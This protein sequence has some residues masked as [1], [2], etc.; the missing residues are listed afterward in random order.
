ME[1]H[2]KKIVLGII[3]HVD[4]GKTTL[5][6]AMLYEAGKI[7]KLGR[8]DHQDAYLDTDEQEKKRGITI[9]SKQ[10]E[11][12]YKNMNITLL[13]T[14]GHVDFSAEMER[15]LQVL[16]YAILVINGMDGVQ[17]HTDT[18][19][20]LL[21]RYNIPAFI[22]INKMDMNG[23]DKESIMSDIRKRLDDNC[24]DMSSEDS[25]E[26]IAMCDEHIMETYLETGDIKDSLISS[27]IRTRKLFPCY[28]GSALKLEGVTEL[29]DSMDR[30][31][32]QPDYAEQFGARVFKISRDV[33]GDR[34]TH[35]KLTGGILKCRDIIGEEKVNQ[36]RIYSGARF[37]NVDMVEAGCICAIT[38]LD[39]TFAGQGLG[40]EKQGILPSLEPV[41]SYKMI[42]PEDIDT[43]LLLRNM[44]K[45]EEEDPQLQVI[46]NEATKEIHLKVMGQ[47]QLQ[48][49][50]QIVKDRYNID[51][52]FGAGQIIYK[53]TIKY[54]VVGVGHFEPL[55]HYAEVHLLMEPLEPGSGMQFDTICS[56]DVLDKN[57]QRLIMTHLEEK[58]YKGVLTGAPVTDMKITITAGRAHNKHTE[59]G[60]FRQATYRAVRQGLM[61]AETVLLEPVYSFRLEVPQDMVGRA[62]SDI[63]RMYGQFSQPE[64]DGD[65]AVLTG[66][67]PAATMQEYHKEV[68]AYTHGTGR[69]SFTLKG[70]E[71][72]HNAEE[73]LST[74]TY[75][76]ETDVSDPS[77][78]VFCAHGA[79][80][81]VDWFDVYDYM[82]V[83]EDQGF[84]LAGMEDMLVSDNS[85]EDYSENTDNASRRMRDRHVTQ[86]VV[87]DD[88]EL[89]DIFVRT[90]G[91]KDRENASYN[92]AGFNRYHKENTLNGRTSQAGKN[93]IGTKPGTT[94]GM[95]LGMPG[96]YK[97]KNGEKEYLL[98]DGY[99]IIFAWEDL[100]ALAEVNLDSARDRLMDL[101]CN[102]QGYT[103]CELILVFDAYKVKQNP[104][105]IEKFNN[106]YV[107]YTKEAETADM[108]IEKTTHQLGRKY[109]VTVA[110]SDGLEQLIIMGQ[111]ALRLSARNFR[112]E[113]DRVNNSIRE[114]ISYMDNGKVTG[115]IDISQDIQDKISDQ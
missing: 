53:E 100:K 7:R 32:V 13:D 59:G 49:L 11:F 47:I 69:L 90:Y 97:K 101:M 42:Y 98:V 105:S 115:R 8:V 54:P 2:M 93:S 66:T 87:Y 55:R 28:F 94:S 58:E 38:G 39:D 18:L 65:M 88:K 44:K 108:Y 86:N 82:H 33:K 5:S 114:K 83:K 20:K 112:E 6:E 22:F 78:S 19:W 85:S 31:M 71:P 45:L 62:M 91:S 41:L 25:L 27:A 60:D 109:K 68:M 61:M 51:I 102:Y 30:Y 12:T 111:G 95:G 89:E 76:P 29:L 16:D 50:T 21:K 64:I 15:T 56:E 10:A 70:Y 34:L 3:A 36:I 92:K 24:I 96:A 77:S 67:G 103:G 23:A 17:S 107:V 74:N 84:A 46:W 75:D 52:S 37:E 48:V 110:T 79:G 80:Y 4:S 63:T 40:I 106:I 73:V 104:G 35:V 1:I 43:S 26:H 9:F 72:C 14:P 81:I 57:W 99:N 113:V